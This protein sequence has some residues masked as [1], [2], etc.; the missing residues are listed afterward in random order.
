MKT[1]T[2]ASEWLKTPFSLIAGAVVLA[3][4][5]ASCGGG[6][7]YGGGGGVVLLP[8]AF[9][10]STPMNGATGVGTTPTL[11]WAVSLYAT[12]YTVE[13]ST[14]NT[15]PLPLAASTTVATTSWTVTPALAAGTYFW[16]VRATDVYGIYTAP[17]FSF[18]T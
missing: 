10:L 7:G 5:L 18:T 8:Q 14:S 12:S 15:F 16:R 1:I 11:T 9:S 6:G 17:T 2:Q 3:F 13:V 4:A